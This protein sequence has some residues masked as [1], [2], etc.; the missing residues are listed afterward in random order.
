MMAWSRYIISADLAIQLGSAGT[1][2]STLQALAN[3]EYDYLDILEDEANL[4]QVDQIS[5]VAS[6]F[7]GDLEQFDQVMSNLISSKI[8]K[9]FLVNLV[10]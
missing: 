2:K 7:T 4:G 1:N 10:R 9:S 6:K 8:S 3:P 5:K